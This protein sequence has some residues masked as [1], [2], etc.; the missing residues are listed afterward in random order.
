MDVSSAKKRVQSGTDKM[1][2]VLGGKY[3]KKCQNNP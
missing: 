2:A 3:V 1:N